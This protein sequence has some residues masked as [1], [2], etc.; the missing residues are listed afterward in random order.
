MKKGELL[1]QLRYWRNTLADAAR[2]EI[3]VEKVLS[4]R[5]VIINWKQGKVSQKQ[6]AELIETIENKLNEKKG[7][8]HRNEPG[9][10]E[11]DEIE[12]LLSPFRVS[13]IPEYTRLTG[14]RGIFYPFWIRAV[15]TKAGFL[16]PDEDTFPYIPRIHLEPQ[17][18]QQVNFIFSTVDAVDLAFSR[19]F[20][21]SELWPD[22]WK[23]IQ[24]TFFLITGVTIDEFAVEN[25]ATTYQPTLVVNETLTGA[26]DAIIRLYD[27]L[28]LD[29]SS[30]PLLTALSNQS[31]EPLKPLLA[32]D[33]FESVSVTH[34][35]QMSH[36]Y[37]LSISQRKSLYYNSQ[38]TEGSILAING[39]PGTGKTTLL[40]SIVANEVVKHALAGE[41]PA[42][43]LAC[44]TN[45]Q[46]VTNIIDSFSTVKAKQGVVYERWL[47]RLKG[48]GLYLPSESK[49]VDNG[50]LH[51]KRRQGGFHRDIEN[52][53][54]VKEAEKLFIDRFTIYSG[55][56]NRSVGQI[57]AELHTALKSKE[58][59]LREGIRIWKQYRTIEE[60]V[61]KLEWQPAGQWPTN[62]QLTALQ[63]T[64]KTLEN[65]VSTYLDNESFWV[66]LF[67]FLRPIKEKRAAR[68]GQLFR[69]CP[70]EYPTLNRYD[71]ATIPIFFDTKFTLIKQIR[72]LNTAWSDWK[73][74]NQIKGNP[75]LDDA[76][77]R[78]AEQ[79]DLPYFYDE[80][81][82][83]LRYDMF[84]LAI[85]YWEGRWIT[86]TRRAL[87][88]DQI[89]KNGIEH[90]KDRW[91]RFAMLTP[92]FVSTFYTAPAFFTYAKFVTKTATG[93]VYE[94]P[95]LRAFIDLL[96]VDEAGQV[97][98]EVG[99]A[100]FG[101]AKR[102]V[103]VGD[104]L[105]IEPVWNVPKK[106]DY[107]NLA[108]YQIIDS[109]ENQTAIEDLLNKGF[110]SSSGS[111]MK[112]A[113]KA[114]A[115]QLYPQGERGML[116]TEHRRCFDEIIDY[117][118]K[119]AYNGLLEPKKG[120]ARN[121][122]FAPIQFFNT[123]G[124][125]KPIGSSRGN[126]AEAVQIADWI[127][128]NKDR[129]LQHYQKQEEAAAQKQNRGVQRLNLS[130]IV[131][132]ITP[133]T[134]Q[135][136]LL[137]AALQKMG[138]DTTGL[139]IGTVHALQGAERPIILFSSTYGKNDRGKSYFFD[140]GVNM[141]NVGVSR[142]K[143]V[144]IFLV[145]RAIMRGK[146]I[147][148][149]NSCTSTFSNSIRFL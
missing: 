138:I 80:L 119:L 15:L 19:P 142:A 86:E 54:Y 37:A 52:R 90:S 92:C 131:G 139:T 89:T 32:P 46:A 133:F 121:N 74:A 28:I 47:P 7:L 112:L 31:Y 57:I 16:K 126:E 79:S 6:A 70:V 2:V 102:S 128:S 135:K 67:S 103:V 61:A 130:A 95:P 82:R 17:V 48:F 129:I 44:S 146:A 98:P 97:A 51:L 143:E 137:R 105:Q 71:L 11:I 1:N 58:Q 30:S 39:P 125:S 148:P 122:L 12:V 29:Q 13:P 96:I 73:R 85:H 65:Q 110:L 111:I 120:P 36:E 45:N 108:R 62:D 84:Y 72:T 69:D 68:L 8:T 99:A 78:A 22:Y 4:I 26:A 134:G 124:D 94:T 104:T 87:D 20:V 141:L 81:E 63:T 145:I 136:Y 149:L 41:D 114:S 127:R 107:A 101:L 9:W 115:Y 100:T 64:L 147:L 18:N 77:V 25:Y 123:T 43:I 106:V 144:F 91:R 50:V 3:P 24:Q 55:E 53:D 93:N 117:C 132:I 113:Q 116:L 83:G 27:S 60:L 59:Q 109:P 5:D 118:N 49:I 140:A 76:A 66:K 56:T 38:L 75:P 23:Y 42:I 34:V 35:G 14:E 40:Q 33:E 21:S 10:E 88:K